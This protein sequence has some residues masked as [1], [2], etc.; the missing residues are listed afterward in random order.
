[1]I[2]DLFK[3]K[4][5]DTRTAI[6]CVAAN[7][8]VDQA[9]VDYCEA[10]LTL[11]EPPPDALTTANVS[12][13]P[14]ATRNLLERVIEHTKDVRDLFNCASNLRAEI[15]VTRNMARYR[16]HIAERSGQ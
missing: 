12:A 9:V 11:L 3:R 15:T 14:P 2:L 13:F 16:A 7:G 6:D 8:A 4:A 5:V 10:L 1:M